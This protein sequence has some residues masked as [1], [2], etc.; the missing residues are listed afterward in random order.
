[1]GG[2]LI[3]G[4]FTSVADE[5]NTGLLQKHPSNKRPGGWG[6]VFKYISD[7]ELQM[8]PNFFYSKK[9]QL[10][11]HCTP[12][13]KLS[14]SI[15]FAYDKK[16]TIYKVNKGLKREKTERFRLL[17]YFRIVLCL[18]FKARPRAKPFI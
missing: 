3:A 1:M 11:Y 9:V 18:F 14:L 8:G 7:G 10:V 15:I 12:I 16:K 17:G 4:L 5:L 6:G 13:T 2:R